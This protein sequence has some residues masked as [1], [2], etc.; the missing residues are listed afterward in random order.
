M[1]ILQKLSLT[2]TAGNLSITNLAVY[3]ALALTVHGSLTGQAS[4]EELIMLGGALVNYSHK[5]YE[6]SK[7]LIESHKQEV[8][9][10]SILLEELKSELSDLQNRNIPTQ[11]DRLESKI[12]NLE[13]SI[14]MRKSK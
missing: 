8:N 11:L 1:N 6:S 13:I 4:I 5:R 12:N 14:N 9:E 3:L 10:A 2:D 7:T